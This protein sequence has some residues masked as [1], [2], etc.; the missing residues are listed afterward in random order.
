MRSHARS[1][2]SRPHRCYYTVLLGGPCQTLPTRCSRD[3]AM[4]A[5]FRLAS[6]TRTVRPIAVDRDLYRLT[7]S[8]LVP[9][10]WLPLADIAG[11]CVPGRGCRSVMFASPRF[12]SGSLHITSLI[13]RGLSGVPYGPGSSLRFALSP[14]PAPTRS[15]RHAPHRARRWCNF[16]QSHQPGKNPY[17]RRGDIV[18]N[19]ENPSQ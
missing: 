18:S 12:G 4:V 1:P 7:A 14:A 10:A 9:G 5:V 2:S 3:T 17:P 8:D 16:S 19:S 13:H 11:F 6:P 15:S